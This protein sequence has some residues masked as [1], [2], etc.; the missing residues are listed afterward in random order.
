[1]LLTIDHP[2]G[3]TRTLNLAHVGEWYYRPAGGSGPSCLKIED[4]R[5]EE[6]F[7]YEG[8]EADAI[9]ATLSELLASGKVAAFRCKLPKSGGP[10][11]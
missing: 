9:H 4:P 11:A 6:K 5:G 7:S 8:P 10:A 3:S 1:M 2:N